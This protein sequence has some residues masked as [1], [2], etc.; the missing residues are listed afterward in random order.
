MCIHAVNPLNVTLCRRR[1]GV[2]LAEVNQLHNLVFLL[3]LRRNTELDSDALYFTL[4]KE[5]Y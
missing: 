5:P 2:T 4:Y 1:G 3:R